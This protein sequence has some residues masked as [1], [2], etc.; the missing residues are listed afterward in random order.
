[1]VVDEHLVG[2]LGDV[3]VERHPPLALFEKIALSENPLISGR[4]RS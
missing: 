2:G 1:M 4:Q 3:A